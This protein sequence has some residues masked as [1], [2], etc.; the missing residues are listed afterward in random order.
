VMRMLPSMDSHLMLRD[1]LRGKSQPL[2][3]V[4]V[5]SLDLGW[6]SMEAAITQHNPLPEAVRGL[7][8]SSFIGLTYHLSSPTNLTRQIDGGPRN[9][10]VVAPRQI[11][12]TPAEAVAYWNHSAYPKILQIFLDGAIYKSAVEEIFDCD[13]SSAELVPQFGV[14]DP[15]LE[16]LAIAITSALRT[17]TSEPLYIDAIAHLI[18]AH[19]A[20]SY[21]ARSS[22]AR[23]LPP[24]EVHPRKMQRVI[25]YIEENLATNLSLEVM[26]AEVEISALYFA[27]TFKAEVGQSPHQYVIA[28]RVERAK[29]LLRDTDMPLD[30][31]AS[32][33]GFSSQSHLSRCFMQHVGIPPGAYRRV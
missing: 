21:S 10:G 9:S 25:E 24:I 15:L 27:R 31:V 17:A 3:R 5:D 26:A 6:R 13:E 19:V 14:I 32:V 30:D 18:A 7:D 22:T 8:H 2:T 12:L 33:V 20:R 1:Q 11:C 29:E 28:R 4:V 23:I 16:Q